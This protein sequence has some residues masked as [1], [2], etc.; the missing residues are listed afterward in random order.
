M[1]AEK[2]PHVV[3]RGDVFDARLDPTEGSEQGGTR[4]VI[5]V[6][7]DAINQASGVIL[8][9]PCTSYRGQ[10]IYPSQALLPAPDG[11]LAVDSLAMAEQTRSLSKSRL[12]RRRGR[13][14]D[15]GLRE[16]ERAVLIALELDQATLARR[17]RS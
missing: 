15:A 3:R 1:S 13:L 7:R 11:G 12:I 9:M 6:S 2:R 17:S 5:V 4:P 8:V 10:R 14:S 16:A